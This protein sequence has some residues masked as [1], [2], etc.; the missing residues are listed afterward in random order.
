MKKCL[1][2][3]AAVVCFFSAE[4]GRA[5]DI[6]FSQFYEN[7]I[8][9]NPALTGIFSGDYK[10]GVNYRTQWGSISNPFQTVL[11][12]VEHRIPISEETSDYLSYGL[13]I[14]YDHAGAI[15]FNSLQ[16][17]PAINY[18]KSLEDKHHSYLSAGFTAGYIQRSVDPSKMTFDNQYQG[19]NYNPNNPTGETINYAKLNHFDLGAGVSFNSSAG[20]N[21]QVNYYIGA[22]A[23]H[24]T[25][26]KEAFNKSESFVRLSTKFTGNVG[27][28]YRIDDQFGAVF[29]FNY[30]NQ[31]PYKETIL[32]AL[33][34]WKPALINS[35]S[36]AHKFNLYGGVF[37]RIN[38]A[39]IPTLK[40][41]YNSYSFTASYDVTISSLRPAISAKGG[42]EFS[43]YARG[44]SKKRTPSMKCPQF[45][46]DANREAFN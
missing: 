25:K 4:T 30:V 20:E 34:S 37:Y 23:F 43:I 24:V 7:S 8:F 45:E 2:F 16:V 12:S 3:A 39:V 42:W 6:H 9:R 26:P 33:A 41:D 44:Y 22:S 40:I 38:D 1:A 17:Y 29:H 19:G 46:D 28:R 36:D 13:C 31:H 11:A 15:N 14:S 32:G 5:Q 27:V 35:M 18:N 21:N 10:V